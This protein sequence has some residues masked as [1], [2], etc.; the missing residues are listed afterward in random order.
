MW[1]CRNHRTRP[2][3]MLAVE[4]DSA[5]TQTTVVPARLTFRV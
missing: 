4:G 3:M 2:A 1:L 5:V